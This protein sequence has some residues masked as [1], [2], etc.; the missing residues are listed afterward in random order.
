MGL[1]PTAGPSPTG[2]ARRT[3]LTGA[4][5]APAILRGQSRRPNVLFLLTDDQRTD[6]IS[7]L[8]NP[9]IRTPHLDGLARRSMVFNNAYCLGSDIPAVC[10]P[11]RNMILSGRAYTR[12]ERQASGD[13]PNFPVSMREAGYETYHE[14]KRGNSALLIQEKFEHNRYLNEQAARQAG[15]PGREIARNAVEFLRGRRAERPFFLYLGFETPHDPRVPRPEDLAHYAERPMPLPRNYMPV[16]PFDNGEM[17]VRDELLAPWPRTEEEVRRHLR[18]Y[19]AVITGLDGE[20]GRVL[21]ALKERPEY[22]NTI[23]IFSSDQGLA[24]GSHGLMGKQSLYD[25]SAKAPL[26]IAGP[27]IQAG[28]SD[29]LVYLMDIFPTVLD[30]VGAPIPG[31]LDGIS[32][33]P[34][35]EGRSRQARADLYL[36]YRGVQRAVRDDRYKLIVYPEVHR[37]QFFDLQA[38]PGELRDLSGEPRQA[39]RVEAMLGRL[40]KLQKQY[41]DAQP[42]A[43]SEPKPQAWVPPKGEELDQIRA[44]WKMPPLSNKPQGEKP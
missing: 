19:Y 25:H 38:D 44:R 7:A 15:A 35:L 39:K 17:T 5:L 4:G 43:A 31:G 37:R 42:L 6:T 32:F 11:S 21:A 22:E 33:R 28:R 16:H 3:L 18:E 10:L 30:Q 29:A 1:N 9:A 34:A 8:G 26:L 20:I 12:Y 36:A 23:V 13:D 41:G 24:V 40:A 27:G 2:I 14:G